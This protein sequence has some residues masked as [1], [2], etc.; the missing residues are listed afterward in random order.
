MTRQNLA[1]PVLFFVLSFG[2][3]LGVLAS[4]RVGKPEPVAA[5]PVLDAAPAFDPEDYT[6]A[7]NAFR[8][9]DLSAAETHLLERDADDSLEGQVILGL[10]RHAAHEHASALEHLH[11]AEAY[12]GELADWRLWAVAES[13]EELDQTL[14]SISALEKLIDQ[15]SSSPLRSHAFRLLSEQALRKGDWPRVLEIADRAEHTRLDTATRQF[16]AR[17]SWQAADALE[18]PVLRR[19]VAHQL[20]TEHPLI[21]SELKVVELLR[22]PDGHVPWSHLFSADELIRRGERLLETDR[23]DLA[24]ETLAE[25]ADVDRGFEWTLV[26]ARALIDDNRGNEALH[27][28]DAVSGATDLERGRLE[29]WQARAA[30]EA[31]TP[32]RG[33]HHLTADQRQHLRERAHQHL[34]HIADGSDSDL[35]ARALRILFDDLAEGENVEER[36]SILRR[37]QALD[38]QDMTGTRALWRLGWKEYSERNYS[39]AIGLWVE[40]GELYPHSNY[41]RSALYWSGRSHQKLGNDDRAQE[42][43]HHVVNV[44]V[45]D[46]YSTLALD[47]LASKP[48]AKLADVEPEEPWPLDARLARADHLYRLGLYEAALIELDGAADGADPR[49]LHGLKARVLAAQGHRRESIISLRRAFPLLGTPHQSLVPLEARQLY[50]PL[51]FQKLV[52]EHS[53]TRFLSRHLVFGMIRQES[54]FDTGATSWAGARGLMQIMPAT[55]KELARRLGLSYTQDRLS[56]PEFSIQLGTSYLQQMMSMFEGDEVLAL[57]GYNAGPYR[58]KRLWREAG[59]GAEIDHFLEQLS[60]EETRTYVKRVLLY[61]D[62]YR[63]LYDSAG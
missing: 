50:Y 17:C 52:E 51:D 42:L 22:E 25:V 36:L 13:A 20:L 11:A 38:T 59:N 24:L 5:L 30:R 14:V 45:G 44:D 3:T 39:G 10:Y 23:A 19:S 16:L 28:L 41:N 46:L 33:R 9:G 54:A 34:R 6:R 58:I 18:D 61:S 37:L 26:Q 63:R 31:A 35:A 29:W 40:L 4:V 1:A 53:R 8:A 56:D 55:G 12:R 48:A 57:A 21:A 49:A 15:H 27:L 43:F 47:R 32:R 60:L 62:S 7:A 2:L